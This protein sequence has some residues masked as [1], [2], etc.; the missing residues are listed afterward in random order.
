MDTVFF[1]A[2]LSSRATI[3]LTGPDW[4]GFLQGLITQDVESLTPGTARF[5]G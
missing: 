3:T 2:E 5:A 4:R 1:V